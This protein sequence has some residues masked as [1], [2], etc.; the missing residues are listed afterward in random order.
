MLVKVPTDKPNICYRYVANCKTCVDDDDGEIL[1]TFLRSV[2]N[3]IR[4]FR[5]EP[6]DVSCI[7]FEQII[8]IIPTPLLK[9]EQNREYYYFDNDIDVL[10]K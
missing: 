3:N 4:K 9:R 6:K 10:E 2:R 5:L 7:N 1:V 8:S